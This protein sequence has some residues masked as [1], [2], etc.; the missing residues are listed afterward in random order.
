M[1]WI[2]QKTWNKE[3]RSYSGV[4]SGVHSISRRDTMKLNTIGRLIGG[5][6]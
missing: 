3:V 2:Q 1:K 6:R 5:D 4:M